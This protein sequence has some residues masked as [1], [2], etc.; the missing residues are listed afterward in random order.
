MAGYSE[1][2]RFDRNQHGGGLLVYVREDIPSH[3]LKT[4]LISLEALFIEINLRKKKWLLCC[5]YNPHKSLISKH[6]N[7]I[8]VVLDI[9]STKYKNL[10]FIGDFNCEYTDSKMIDFCQNYELANLIKK[11]YMF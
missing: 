5:S 1:P 9:Q 11:V 10:L 7:E 3:I 8:Q 6:L 2:Y 4:R